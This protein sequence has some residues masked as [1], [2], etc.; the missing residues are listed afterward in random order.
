[1]RSTAH[2]VDQISTIFVTNIG[3][4]ILHSLFHATAPQFPFKP[5]LQ[6]NPS[7]RV[8]AEIAA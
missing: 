5:R 3:K 2:A 6:R 8:A 7:P 1:M 4:H